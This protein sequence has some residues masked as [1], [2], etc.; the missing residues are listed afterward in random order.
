MAPRVTSSRDR[1]G[2]KPAKPTTVTTSKGRGN[3]SS[4]STANVSSGSNGKP[5]AAGARV[6][7]ASQRTSNGSARVTGGSRAALPPG[8]KGGAVTKPSSNKPTAPRS[9]GGP[10]QQVRVRDMGR[11]QLPGQFRGWGNTSNPN[12]FPSDSGRPR[13]ATAEQ[14]A[15]GA[16]KPPASA[17][18]GVRG[19][20]P[21]RAP[22]RMGGLKGGIVGAVGLAAADYLGTKAGNAIGTSIR[23]A[24]QPQRTGTASGRT[25]RGG[26]TNDVGGNPA[27]DGRYIPGSQQ[28]SFNKPKP[29]PKPEAP[30]TRPATQSRSAASPARMPSAVT[31]SSSPT[32]AKPKAPQSSGYSAPKPPNM[33][34][35][36]TTTTDAPKPPTAKDLMKAVTRRG[37]GR[38]EM[39]QDNLRRARKNRG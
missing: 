1:A 26:T 38:D 28:V 20:L 17:S 24:S 33:D 6:T 15:A 9:N 11:P 18:G 21:G 5:P 35:V 3:R 31:R 39:I 37:V 29:A 32:G 4:V 30:A 13:G 19:L 12:S 16:P 10:V 14:R 22:I 2:R 23:N 27:R 36:E 34:K 25:G 7:N 8:N